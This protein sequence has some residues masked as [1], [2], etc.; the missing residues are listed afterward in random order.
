MPH[1]TK[2]N[3]KNHNISNNVINLLTPN[4]TVGNN[5]INLSNCNISNYIANISSILSISTT[6]LLLLDIINRFYPGTLLLYTNQ[7]HLAI[8]RH[9]HKNNSTIL[10]IERN[11]LPINYPSNIN[12]NHNLRNGIKH[13]ANLLKTIY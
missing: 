13:K 1:Q 9:S 5:I 7:K 11:R 4:C 3:S 8:G 2:P 12:L 10:R 6:V